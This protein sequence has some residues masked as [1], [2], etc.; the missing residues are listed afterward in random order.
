[1]GIRKRK[2]IFDW[3]K[4]EK[5]AVDPH[6]WLSP[7]LVKR[8]AEIIEKSLEQIDPDGRNIYR[9][10][11]K[12]FLS[13]IDELD[14]EIENILKDE[15]GKAFL[16]FHPCWGYFAE[17]YGLRQIPIEMQG[18][19][20][21]GMWLSRIVNYCKKMHVR[22]IFVQPQFSQKI[23]RLIAKEI[24]ARLV[25]IDPLSEN[26]MENLKYVAKKIKEAISSSS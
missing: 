4:R 13:Q 8:Q 14:Q 6:I 12:R 23:P 17:R 20:P 19:E 10:N 22:V 2:I 21:S 26:W 9:K 15:K 16:V 11:F 3:L 7:P 5:E 1:M 18:R 24:G 25:V